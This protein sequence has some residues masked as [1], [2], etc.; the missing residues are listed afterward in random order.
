MWSQAVSG[1]TFSGDDQDQWLVSQDQM[2]T[3]SAA[4]AFV[5][6]S[7]SFMDPSMT[8]GYYPGQI[9]MSEPAA[10]ELD[11]SF[12]VQQQ[13]N[14]AV[15]TEACP[16]SGF[17]YLASNPTQPSHPGP[18]T[19]PALTES[20]SPNVDTASLATTETQFNAMPSFRLPESASQSLTQMWYN[21]WGQVD[22]V[23][24]GRRQRSLPHASLPYTQ[25]SQSSH[26]ASCPQSFQSVARTASPITHPTTGAEKGQP[27]VASP[28]AEKS[29][30]VK[31][32]TLPKLN[33]SRDDLPTKPKEIEGEIGP[34]RKH[35][36][37]EMKPHSDGLYHCPYRS[38]RDPKARCQHDPTKLKCNYDKYIDSHLKPYRCKQNGCETLRFSSTACRLRHER[39]AHGS[40]GHGD[41][42]FRCVFADCERSRPDRGFPRQW[43]RRDHM[44]RVHDYVEPAGSEHSD[45]S[46]PGSHSGDVP[47]PLVLV[48]S[49]PAGQ[50]C[51]RA[52]PGPEISQDLPSKYRK[53]T[54]TQA[55]VVSGTISQTQP[56]QGH[57]FSS[58]TD[59][60]THTQRSFAD[61]TEQYR[62]RLSHMARNVK[63]PEDMANILQ[64]VNN[65]FAHNGYFNQM[66]HA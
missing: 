5:Y 38:D 7:G 19:T 54:T 10:A 59:M 8:F 29:V 14:L 44:K 64:E 39:E 62:E 17:H 30:I 24:S 22:Q 16:P 63:G 35:P 11:S 18:S 4:P 52:A 23:S 48:T 32:S 46:A 20:S 58:P 31:R 66:P 26:E 40:H 12:N 25:P 36:H 6:E 21:N 51:K 15:S 33:Q 27:P 28:E 2:A 37:Y 42:P 1:A 57:I 3:S 13:G 41:K 43:N 9:P 55:G 49:P 53:V 61:H 45:A 34:G 47:P 50:S 56:Q 65:Y 60:N